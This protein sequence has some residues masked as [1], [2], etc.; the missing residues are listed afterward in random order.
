MFATS[1]HQFTGI[2][3]YKF[4]LKSIFRFQNFGEV[5][6]FYRILPGVSFVISRTITDYDFS[7]LETYSSIVRV[8]LK[9][10]LVFLQV[11]ADM[12]NGTM[13]VSVLKVTWNQYRVLLQKQY[14]DKYVLIRQIQLQNIEQLWEK[15]IVIPN[16]KFIKKRT[17][18]NS[19]KTL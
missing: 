2:Y 19:I 11:D 6:I 7:K 16:K 13:V 1:S 8:I 9:E 12:K 14:M 18:T 17:S 10:I 3:L 4:L 15:L 5:S